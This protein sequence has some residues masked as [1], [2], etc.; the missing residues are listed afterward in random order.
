MKIIHPQGRKIVTEENLVQF[1]QV[2]FRGYLEIGSTVIE[3]GF[4]RLF[5]VITLLPDPLVLTSAITPRYQSV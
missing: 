5:E 1:W 4:S 2:C 3:Y